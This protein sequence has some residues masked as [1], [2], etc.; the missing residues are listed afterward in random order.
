MIDALAPTRP[1][2]D[3]F[4]VVPSL[5]KV[6]V[7]YPFL[8][9][10]GRTNTVVKKSYPYNQSTSLQEI[11]FSILA[12]VSCF[13]LFQSHHVTCIPGQYGKYNC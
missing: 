7:D 8:F 1:K 13:P 5:F 2:E 10:S 12:R 6:K 11:L 9:Y 4:P 3:R